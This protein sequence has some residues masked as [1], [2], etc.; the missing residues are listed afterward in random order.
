M[1]ITAKFSGIPIGPLSREER[2]ERRR[3][4]QEFINSLPVFRQDLKV[5]CPVRNHDGSTIDDQNIPG[6]GSDH[7]VWSGDVYDC[8]DCG[9]FF[10]AWAADPPHRR[11]EED[12]P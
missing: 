4:H 9:I 8:L 11:Q 1:K 12:E 10:A 5:R 7:V 3:K 6:C 2:A